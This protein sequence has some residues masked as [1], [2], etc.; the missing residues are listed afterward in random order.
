[1]HNHYEIDV[2]EA[3]LQDGCPRCAEHAEHPLRDLDDRMLRDLIELAT[4]PRRSE[5][6]RSETEA[7]AAA[8]V[9]T[10]LERT[11][12]LCEVAGEVVAEYL[13]D[14]WHLEADIKSLEI[15]RRS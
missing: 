13:R 3:G 2:H 15:L 6:V 12:K 10:A 7:I 1:M 8:N 5:R 11:G 4:S 14:R 9:M